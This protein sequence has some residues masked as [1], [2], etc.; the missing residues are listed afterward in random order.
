MATATRLNSFP[1]ITNYI[2]PVPGTDVTAYLAV[3][4]ANPT[5]WIYSLWTNGE[6]EIIASDQVTLPVELK[7]TPQQVARVAFLLSVEYTN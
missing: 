2:V 3:R 1:G 6:D 4:D 5:E 7:V